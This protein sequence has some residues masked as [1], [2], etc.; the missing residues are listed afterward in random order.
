MRGADDGEGAVEREGRRPEY[1]ATLVELTKKPGQNLGEM[2]QQNASLTGFFP[3]D[4]GAIRPH[5]RAGS[6]GSSPWARTKRGRA[7]PHRRRWMR[8]PAT[9][10]RVRARLVCRGGRPG[11]YVGRPRAPARP[12]G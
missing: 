8:Q 9:T 10:L 2:L 12:S 6:A 1:L 11:A 3:P 7:R 5:P 4:P